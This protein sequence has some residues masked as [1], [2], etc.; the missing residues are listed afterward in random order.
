MNLVSEAA[1]Q[2]AVRGYARLTGW[3]EHVVW[4]SRKSPEGWPDLTLVRGE[5]IVMAELKTESGRLSPA[6][7]EWL[8]RLRAT[9]KVEVFVWRPRDW[10]EIEDELR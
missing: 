1:F 5:R 8:E 6:Q 7:A 9:G 10:P 4:D 3:A 2:E